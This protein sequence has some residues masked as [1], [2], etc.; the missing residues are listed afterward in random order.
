[1]QPA[2]GVCRLGPLTRDW[3]S[4]LNASAWNAES[5]RVCDTKWLSE[6]AARKHYPT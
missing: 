1:M 6:R 4:R 3:I 5:R 2:N